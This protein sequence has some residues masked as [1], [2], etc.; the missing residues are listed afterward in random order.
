MCWRSLKARDQREV[1]A[2]PGAESLI[3]EAVRAV[4]QWQVDLGIDQVSDGEMGTR[5]LL[6]IRDRTSHRFDG[7]RQPMDPPVERSM[8]PE[9]YFEVQ[10]GPARGFGFPTCTGQIE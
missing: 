1:Y 8:F 9:S 2:Q 7:P 5:R 6:F 3:S 10:A 4:V